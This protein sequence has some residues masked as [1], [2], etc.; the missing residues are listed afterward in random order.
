[1]AFD[2]STLAAAETG[3]LELVTP[4]GDELL[5]DKGEPCTITVF[6]P[7]T[8]Q[9]QKALSAKNRAVYEFVKRGGRKMKDG[10]QREIDA[11]FLADITAS[12]NG[13]GYKDLKGYEMFNALYSDETIGFIAEQVNAFVNDW[14]NFT[15]KPAKT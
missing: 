11:R 14:G 10:E 3:T 7:G 2:I 8:K 13:F 9:Y 1:M 4:G 5:N 12:F 15:R 6:S